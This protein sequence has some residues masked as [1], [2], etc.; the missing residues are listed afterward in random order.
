MLQIDHR[1]SFDVDIFIDDPQALPYLN[2]Q[3]QGIALDITLDAYSSDG[4]HAFKIVFKD[5][6]EIDFIVAPALTPEPYREKRYADK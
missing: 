4:T 2:P 6:G 1:E 3:T 5:I